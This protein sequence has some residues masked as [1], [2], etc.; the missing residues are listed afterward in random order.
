MHKYG[1]DAP[2]PLRVSVSVIL[3]R[4]I[5]MSVANAFYDLVLFYFS[6]CIMF[7]GKY[8]GYS[9]YLKSIESSSTVSSLMKNFETGWDALVVVAECYQVCPCSW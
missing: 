6:A 5:L 9:S 4:K 7:N 3:V 2:L 8:S 1:S